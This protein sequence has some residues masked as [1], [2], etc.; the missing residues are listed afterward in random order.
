MTHQEKQ[1]ACKGFFVFLI[2]F[3]RINGSKHSK[4]VK[5][6]SK[7]MIVADANKADYKGAVLL[8]KR[9]VL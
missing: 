3:F 9:V 2:I 1:K 6:F 4:R 5:Y 7:K 8:V